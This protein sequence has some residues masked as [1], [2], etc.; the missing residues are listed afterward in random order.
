MLSCLKLTNAH[1]VRGRPTLKIDTAPFFRDG[2][3]CELKEK[4]TKLSRH[5]MTSNT[6]RRNDK[7]EYQ[8]CTCKMDKSLKRGMY[9]K[10]ESLK[11]CI[12][13][14]QCNNSDLDIH[15][16]EDRRLPVFIMSSDEGRDDCQQFKP[17]GS[18]ASFV[19]T[20]MAVTI[21]PILSIVFRRVTV[22]VLIFV[23]FVE[24]FVTRYIYD[25]RRST[26]PE[27]PRKSFQLAFHE[28]GYFQLVERLPRENVTAL[29]E[30]TVNQ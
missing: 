9:I 11:I 7:S 28:C 17:K 29:G 23:L 20:V 14:N 13:G 5:S 2:L 22:D 18:H 19:T 8:E 15:S 26:C 4:Q 30:K 16:E 24:F 27:G 12:A 21:L 25:A 3:V 1:T 10:F 6:Q